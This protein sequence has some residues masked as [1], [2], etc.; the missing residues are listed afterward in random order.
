M[1]I[2]QKKYERFNYFIKESKDLVTTYEQT[3]AGFLSIA[4]EKNVIGDP[5]VKNA[6]AF[7]VMVANTKGPDD[8]LE[9][10][11]VRPFL[12]TAAGISEKS[13]ALTTFQT[14][15]WRD[16]CSSTC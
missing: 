12:L 16:C 4:L 14:G 9:L 2:V 6:L 15:F 7:K 10:P 13:C 5:F 8:F 3:R 1:S 11:S